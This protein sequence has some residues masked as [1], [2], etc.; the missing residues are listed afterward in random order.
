MKVAIGAFSLD[1]INYC[2]DWVGDWEN[3]CIANSIEFKGFDSFDPDFIDKLLAYNPDATLWRSGNIPHKKIKDE[4]QR[5]F[6]DKT[7]LRILPNWRTH[8]IYDHKIRQSY[9]FEYHNIP[10]PETKVFFSESY[11]LEYIEKAEYPF[12]VKADGGA[13]GRSFRF[14]ETKEQALVRVNEA[15][16]GRGRITGREHEKNIL[17]VQ[18]YIAATQIWRIGVFKNKVGFGFI[19]KNKLET[20]VASYRG[21]KVY[22]P[23]PAPLLNMALEINQRMEWDWMMYDFI[24]SEKYGEY[25]VLEITDTCDTGGP[26]G[27]SLTYYREG[28]KWISKKKTPPPQEIIFNLFILEKMRLKERLVT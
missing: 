21:V 9:L 11:A 25:L 28:D 7:N 17:Y 2:I 23:V 4:M 26:A 18:E 15:F 16:G 12:V 1:E 19:Q 24:W 5:Q 6:L 3:L 27:R 13:G 20:K 10:H 22:P 14:I 8:Y